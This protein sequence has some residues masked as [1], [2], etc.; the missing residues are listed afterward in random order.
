MRAA[1]QSPAFCNNK[2]IDPLQGLSAEYKHFI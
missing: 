2:L 1:A